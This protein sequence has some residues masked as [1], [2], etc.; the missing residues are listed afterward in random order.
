MNNQEILDNAP[1]GASV[2]DIT[3]QYFDEYNNHL[4]SRGF[5]S[6]KDTSPIS[7]RSLADIAKIEE[8]EAI[9][10]GRDE[11]INNAVSSRIAELEN[12]WISVEDKLP[13]EL[14]SVLSF[15]SYDGVF[16]SN[17]RAGNF[18]K[19]LVVWEHL[20]VTHW[21]PLPEPPKEQE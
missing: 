21:M 11:L 16:Q 19:T 14:Q 2:S 17:Y 8:L 9:I 4:N 5:W 1:K 6:E 15:A 10:R 13:D 18:K 12:Q 20:N 7:P 3:G